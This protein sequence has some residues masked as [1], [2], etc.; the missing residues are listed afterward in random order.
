MKSC[1]ELIPQLLPD[2]WAV[3]IV[4]P[5]QTQ[6][7]IDISER[8][9]WTALTRLIQHQ[10]LTPN[11][12]FCFFIDGLDE[13]EETTQYDYRAV[14]E[15]LC[16]WSDEA[17]ESIKLCISSREYNVFMN[18]FSTDR[19]LR[20]HELTWQD[21][22]SFI[23]AKLSHL[24]DSEDRLKLVTSII[25]K[26]QGIFLWVA[27][28]TKSIRDQLEN[29]ATV[30]QME[31]E[32]ETIPDEMNGLY[33]HIIKSLSPTSRKRAYRNLKLLEEAKSYQEISIS[34]LAYSFL[35]DYDQDPEF[36]MKDDFVGSGMRSMTREQRI[37]A[38]RKSLV[39][40]CRGLIEPNSSNDLDYTHRS[41]AEFLAFPNIRDAMISST[42]NF[43]VPDAIS[44][45]LLA[46]IRMQ[47]P[48]IQSEG[49]FNVVT[50]NQSGL[51]F[52]MRG[53]NKLDHLPY[54]YLSFFERVIDPFPWED[55]NN[56]D[57]GEWMISFPESH[58]LICTSGG[59]RTP[60]SMTRITLPLHILT[61]LG[62]HDYPIWKILH[63]T[64]TVDTVTKATFL[65]YCAINHVHYRSGILPSKPSVFDVLLDRSLLGPNTK[66]HLW[67]IWHKWA[68]DRAELTIWQHFLVKIFLDRETDS[69]P[70]IFNFRSNI[71]NFRSSVFYGRIVEGFLRHKPALN[72]AMTLGPVETESPGVQH[73]FAVIRSGPD[74]S[75][76]IK[77]D[78]W[79]WISGEPF[80]YPSLRTW[81]EQTELENK[82][83]LLQMYDSQVE[84]TRTA[85]H[86]NDST[87]PYI[88]IDPEYLGTE[89]VDDRQGSS[90]PDT[91]DVKQCGS[92]ERL[93]MQ[94]PG[95][96]GPHAKLLLSKYFFL[97]VIIT[98]TFMVN[99]HPRIGRLTKINRYLDCCSRT[100]LS[101]LATTIH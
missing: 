30:Y 51:L 58:T 40:S 2:T 75:E 95:N 81:I 42:S 34:L 12:C 77:I 60:H 8:E 46:E 67:P 101:S 87:A 64:A 53:E 88:G 52:L 74:L 14:A 57:Y 68:G 11:Y 79:T 9:V 36:A 15:L 56:V 33:E 89:S 80:V 100:K 21:M 18:M 59:G 70:D 93:K 23:S 55:L 82:D 45:L 71:S 92:P 47:R 48:Q 19:R 63:D 26:A 44:Q 62:Y 83:R 78:C 25:R 69:R 84:E 73:R 29:G 16:S 10:T 1:P 43:N 6:T 35:E 37:E 39:G 38:A 41:V 99:G 54:A 65:M 91:S 13:F 49:K 20:L 86:Q 66:T 85:K 17:P 5:W 98:G 97:I 32:L 7:A 28:V 76:S 22:K 31:R 96:D 94:S 61:V 72:F 4:A 90:S 3:A 27:L 24:P 50:R